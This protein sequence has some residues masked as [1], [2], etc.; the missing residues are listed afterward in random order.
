MKKGKLALVVGVLV[1]AIGGYAYMRQGGEEVAEIEYRYAP[2]AKGELVRSISATGQVV[3]LTKVDV[4]SKAGGKVVRLAVDEGS[5]VRQGDLIA[6][7]DPE[8]TRA[9]YEQATADLQTADARA[10]QAQ[11]NYEIQITQAEN[12]I[13]DAKAALDAA[14]ARYERAG[15]ES[16]RQPALTS[17][18]IA[19]A[20]ASYESAQAALERLKE[21][22]VPQMRREAQANLAQATTQRDTA[23]ANLKRSEDLSAKGFVA[24]ASVDTARASAEAAKTAF[25]IAQQRASTIEADI[26][27]TIRAQEKQVDQARA[28]LDQARTNAAQNDISR[29][30]TVEALNNVRA[31]EVALKRA[32]DSKMQ[33]AIRRSEI[34]AARASTVRNRVSL[35]NAKVQLDSTTVVAPRDGVVT[36]K[37]LEEG[38]IIPP[39]MS[40]F[41]QGTSLVQLSDV[42]Q[43]YVECAVDEADISNV[44]AGQK[45]RITT[46]AFPG[47]TFDGVVTRVNPAAVTEQNIT[48]VKVRVKVL[49]GAKIRVL[50]GMNAT[51]E[52]ITMNKKDIIVVPNQAVNNEGGKATVRVKGPDPKKPVV[53]E[54][55]TG[56]TGNEGIEIVSGIKEGEEVVTAEI[57][58]AELR[59]IQKKMQEVQEGGGLA[60]GAPNRNQR[61]TGATTRGGQAAGGGRP[62]APAGGAARPAAP[63]PAAPAGGGR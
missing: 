43:L 12:D 20:Q 53:R 15:L 13:Q 19:N 33:I 1:L 45:V 6:T 58:V 16:R 37:Y 50:P 56:E 5:V 57:D 46:E 44:K 4:K 17:S 14:R 2:V 9:I 25:S 54:V 10:D 47:D 36:M 18:N 35:Q 60:G 26:Q 8:D 59:E 21:V 31:A 49:P 40:T 55:V 42:T 63:K 38:T 32:I 34:Q 61:R 30:S 29:V 22:T 24:G 39:G 41:A 51:C 3:A 27:T 7:I 62:A 23:L 48:A 11:R 52:F 28:A